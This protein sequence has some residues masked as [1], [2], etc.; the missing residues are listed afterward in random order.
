MQKDDEVEQARQ[1]SIASYRRLVDKAFKNILNDTSVVLKASQAMSVTGKMVGN[2]EDIETGEY[3]AQMFEALNQAA[4]KLRVMY[5]QR[6]DGESATEDRIS[7]AE[8]AKLDK[9]LEDA[10]EEE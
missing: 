5:N 2:E 1:A 9:A 4:E 7:D 3:M 10:D 8:W 6:F